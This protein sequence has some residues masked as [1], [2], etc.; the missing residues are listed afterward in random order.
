MHDDDDVKSSAPRSSGLPP[1]NHD[2]P[3]PSSSGFAAL[4][5]RLTPHPYVS[6]GP[7]LMGGGYA[8]LAWRFEGGIDVESSQLVARARAAYDNGRQVNDGDQPNP[9][10]HDRYLDAGIYVRPGLSS[11][12]GFFGFGWRWNQL[13][14]T[15][16]VK[17]ANRPQVGG[18]YDLMCRR[19]FSMR[20]AIN[21]VMAGDDWQNGVHGP[22][23][24]LSFPSLREKRHWFWQENV[25]V[26]RFH[27]T[28]TEPGNVSFTRLRRANRSTMVN[29]NFGIVYRF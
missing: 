1:E 18:G 3:A 12:Q 23:F 7:A 14:T 27:E 13:S 16:Y 2:T 21:W 6:T 11:G 8:P 25:G 22:E 26:Y 19:D 5:T 28:V 29:V 24:S 10:G 9:K 20:V 4:M 17:S 15:N